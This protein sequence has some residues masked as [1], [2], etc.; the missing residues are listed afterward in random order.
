M[1]HDSPR[2]FIDR[3]TAGIRAKRTPL[4]VG[5]DPHFEFLPAPFR[6]TVTAA[7]DTQPGRAQAAAA[8]TAFCN[9]VVQ[10]V[11][12]LVAA[13]KP[14][15]AFFEQW[16]PPGMSGLFQVIQRAQSAKLSIIL[17]GKRN[18]IGSTAAAYAQALLGPGEAS[19][20]GGDALTVNPWLGRD[21]V[22]P[23]VDRCREVGSGLFVLVKTSNSGSR[24]FQDLASTDRRLYEHVAVMVETM[25]QQSVGADGYGDIGAVIGATYPEELAELRRQMPHTVFLIPG[26]GAQGGRAADIACAFDA[27]GLG[28]VVNSARGIL[29]A[30]RRESP[31][32]NDAHWETAVERATREAIAELAAATPAGNLRTA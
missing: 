9:E 23:F 10:I 30:F 5:I 6:N 20:F 27:R 2:K 22:Q 29:F 21:S 25:A 28:A 13:V 19:A 16:G 4:I 3:L 24:D 1:T 31:Q 14:Q 7:I 26:F 15:L 32:A 12:P 17:D 11:G 18:D 8:C